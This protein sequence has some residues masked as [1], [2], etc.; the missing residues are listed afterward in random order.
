MHQTKSPDMTRPISSAPHI[1][2]GQSGL[3]VRHLA[4]AALG[5]T[6]AGCALA[7]AAQAQPQDD[8]RAGPS[9]TVGIAAA[10]MPRF[11]GADSSRTRALPLLSYRNGRFFAGTLG[12]VGYDLSTVDG[13]SFGPLLSYRFGRDDSDAQR[14]RGLGDIDAG[15]DLG[16]YLRWNLRPFFVHA[17]LRQGVTGDGKGLQARVGAGLSLALTPADRLVFD[18]SVDWADA[19]VMQTTFGV[20][21]AQS[22]ASGLAAYQAGAGIR[23]M[24]LGATWTHSFTPQ[25]FTTVGAGLVRLGGAA[26][27]SPITQDRNGGV[28]SV[29][30]GYRF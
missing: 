7:V 22:A 8:A 29:G 2:S 23:R 1:K 3:P 21:A 17:N 30:V 20:T 15:L 9:W 18:A 4:H 12:G 11:E 5:A 26:A 27:D 13:L 25:W 16:G 6:L 19:D 28:F 10:H 24:G 14:L